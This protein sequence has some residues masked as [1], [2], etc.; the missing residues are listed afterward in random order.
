MVTSEPGLYVDIYLGILCYGR[1]TLHLSK[2]L[3]S[4]VTMATYHEEVL[5]YGSI[6]THQQPRSQ[7]IIVPRR[8][9]LLQP[10][11]RRRG[12][13]AWPSTRPSVIGPDVMTVSRDLVM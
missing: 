8:R 9:L 2:Q 4:L 13:A 10:R 11:T 12:S 3:P 1:D 5:L 7:H 6:I